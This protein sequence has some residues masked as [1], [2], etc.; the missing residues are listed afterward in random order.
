MLLA[1]VIRP[2]LWIVSQPMR[3]M[4]AKA[5]QMLLARIDHVEKGGPVRVSFTA[6][7]Q[8]GDSVKS[9]L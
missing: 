4:S 8:R 6:D 2:K 1:K 3:E 7:I 9:F 5:V